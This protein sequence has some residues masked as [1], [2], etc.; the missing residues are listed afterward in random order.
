MND[1]YDLDKVSTY[2]GGWRTTRSF[3]DRIASASP[4]GRL[5]LVIFYF[6]FLFFFFSCLQKKDLVAWAFLL[7]PLGLGITEP[8]WLGG[9]GAP[10]KHDVLAA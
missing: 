9:N 10:R 6:F 3:S 1:R 4:I 5:G 2:F 8:A 7:T